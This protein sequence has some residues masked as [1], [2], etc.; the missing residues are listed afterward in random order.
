[1]TIIQRQAEADANPEE[2]YEAFHVRCEKCSELLLRHVYTADPSRLEEHGGRPGDR[3]PSFATVNGAVVATEMFN[4]DETLR[5]CGKCG[6]VNAPFPYDT[7]GWHHFVRQQRAVN[8]SRRGM[9]AVADHRRSP[10][11]V[12]G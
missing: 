10:A 2:Q 5:T 11:E 12:A 6:H 4:S 1:M 8:E 7:W 3:F 9:L